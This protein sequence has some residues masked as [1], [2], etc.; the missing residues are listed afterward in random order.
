MLSH[1]EQERR[2][3]R[4]LEKQDVSEV[5]FHHRYPTSTPNVRNACH[6]FSTKDYFQYQYI[7]VHNGVVHNS[8]VLKEQHKA[9]GIEYVSQQENGK[10]NDSEA[11]TYD[12][13]RL[14]EGQVDHLTASGSIAF[15]A[16]KRDKVTG[17][18]LG[19]FYGRNNGN[20]LKLKRTKYSLT[21]SSEGEGEIVTI[22]NIYYVNYDTG[23]TSVRSVTIPGGYGTYS[24]FRGNTTTPRTVHGTTSVTPSSST[25]STTNVGRTTGDTPTIPSYK[26]PTPGTNPASLPSTS[27]GWD[28]NAE[29]SSLEEAW[30]IEADI[31]DVYED[32]MVDASGDLVNALGLASAQM[33]LLRNRNDTIDELSSSDEWDFAQSEE[34]IN[35]YVSNEDNI[36]YLEGA[37]R[38]IQKQ[39]IDL[40]KK[41]EPA[42][43]PIGFRANT[44]Q[45]SLPV[46]GRR[47]E[48]HPMPDAYNPHVTITEHA[49]TNPS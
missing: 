20:P 38:L 37:M 23:Q 33:Q 24:G 21:L 36:R 19:V 27:Q 9:L 41:E 14:F 18:T 48:V 31:K 11:L 26:N 40:D 8:S 17:K 45:S 7:I 4:R 12:L 49:G 47:T 35:E 42:K 25:G 22:N 6:P 30:Q 46:A 28:S 2:I 29:L 13:A 34:T 15:I 32:L 3:L 44:T 10:F 1:N 5:L 16:L 43:Q 39:I